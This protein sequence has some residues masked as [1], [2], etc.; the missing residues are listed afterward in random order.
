MIA[1]VETDDNF[2]IFAV[3]VNYFFGSVVMSFFRAKIISETLYK[4]ASGNFIPFV[5]FKENFF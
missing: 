1:I 4:N 3:F 2:V 5:V